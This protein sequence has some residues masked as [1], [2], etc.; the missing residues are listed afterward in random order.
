MPRSY[1]AYFGLA[2]RNIITGHSGTPS[3]SKRGALKPVS[4]RGQGKVSRRGDRVARSFIIQGAATIYMLYCKDML[5]ECQL[6]RWLHE[7]IKRGKPYGKIIVSLAAKLL[8]IVWALLTYGEN[9]TVTKRAY[10]ARCL[11]LWKSPLS[12]TLRLNLPRRG[13]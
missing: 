12:T 13:R 11:R 5:P 4:S 3:P 10:H 6:R 8:R 2:P 1:A 7:Q 9:S